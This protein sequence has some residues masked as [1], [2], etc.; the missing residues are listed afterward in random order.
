VRAR[1]G[2]T[3]QPLLKQG[4]PIGITATLSRQAAAN[5]PA[6]PLQSRHRKIFTVGMSSTTHLSGRWRELATSTAGV[7]IASRERGGSLSTE[8]EA[9]M[10]E[11]YTLR[12]RIA[13]YVTYMKA[14][15]GSFS[16]PT[17][18]WLPSTDE[19]DG[20]RLKPPAVVRRLPTRQ[21]SSARQHIRDRRWG[22][23][24]RASNGAFTRTF[25]TFAKKRGANRQRTPIPIWPG[26]HPRRP[27]AVW[28]R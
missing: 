28:L 17:F 4:T 10:R 6:V 14:G 2:C 5:R 26:E 16:I 23:I 15:Q 3:G 18:R 25:Q 11:I 27:T 12:R 8:G 21:A 1:A 13:E 7:G 20:V 22:P 24:S 19:K 9:R